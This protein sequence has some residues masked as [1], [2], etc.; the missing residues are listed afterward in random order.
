M[1]YLFEDRKDRMQQLLQGDVDD[2]KGI[3]ST[4]KVIS[5]ENE[6]EVLTFF[7]SL[8]DLDVVI[9]HSSYVFPNKTLTSENIKAVVRKLNK[10]FVLFSGGL[11]NAIINEDEVVLNSGTFYKNLKTFIGEYQK[12]KETDLAHLI[13]KNK[14]E[15]LKHQVKKFQNMAL[16]DLKKLQTS[17]HKENAV[18]TTFKNIRN[19]LDSFLISS[20]FEEDKQM[21]SDYIYK[22]LKNKDFNNSVLFQQINK[23][24]SKYENN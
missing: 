15:Y 19:A 21:L 10:K 1:I 3:L 13:F 8:E 9:L 16:S 5:Q 17:K 23:M 14:N 22:R 6:E 18:A 2:F 12:N 20:E 11:Y 24:I 7:K 4:D